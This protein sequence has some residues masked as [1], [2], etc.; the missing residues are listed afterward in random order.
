[1]RALKLVLITLAGM[2]IVPALSLATLYVVYH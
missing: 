1:M 2:L